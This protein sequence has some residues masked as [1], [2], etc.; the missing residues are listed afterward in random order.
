ML[1]WFVVS[2]AVLATAPA[3]A[4]EL[5]LQDALSQAAQ[6][7]LDLASGRA[8]LEQARAQQR[9]ALAG[10][11]PHLSVGGS[12]T[13]N[14]TE[15]EIALPTGYLIRDVG[16]PQGPPF[17]P[18]REPG[19]D[20]PPGAQTPL[21]MVPESFTELTV[22]RRHQLAAQADFRQVIFAPTLWANIVAAGKATKMAELRFEHSR[23]ELLYGVAQAWFA[24]AGLR[25]TALVQERLLQTVR[26]QADNAKVRVQA[27]AAPKLDALRAEIDLAQSEQDL[28]RT[29]LAYESAR[30][31]LATLL[32]R[33]PD[34]EVPPTGQ[35][36]PPAEPPPS[37]ETLPQAVERSDVQAARV[38]QDLA[39]SARR[40]AL[41]SYLPTL[42]FSAR[43]QI[44]NVE[45]FAGRPDTWALTL[46][47]NWTLWDGGVREAQLREARAAL[48]EAETGVRAARLRAED[49][50][51]RAYLEV[52]S[53]RANQAKALRQVELARES[54]QLAR[55]A[56]E[57]GAG[58][59]L[60]VSLATSA[61]LGAELSLLG[62]KVSAHLATLQVLKAAGAF[63]VKP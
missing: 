55:T 20:N 46:G 45:G 21:V 63:D 40:G 48:V 51:R 13:L 59:S 26:Q 31:S 5:S 39:E 56:W 37:E 33:A 11:L 4:P 41:G 43:Y 15:A 32:G 52:Q 25:E 28:E 19:V 16:A 8:R 14:S 1:A 57:A 53:A 38:Q 2:S 29:R 6:E 58:T 54:L 23:Q 35:L 42:S 10:Y 18:S 49:E 27:G 9:Q 17:D 3:L 12:Y 34:F 36:P 60:D 22:Q 61:L 7:N 44:A 62:E 50:L 47:A 24:A 30:S